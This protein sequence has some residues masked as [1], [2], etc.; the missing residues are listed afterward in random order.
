MPTTQTSEDTN[1]RRP[2]LRARDASTASM[3]NAIRRGT[4][5]ISL[6]IPAGAGDHTHLPA[7]PVG[8]MTTASS[9]SIRAPARPPRDDDGGHPTAAGLALGAHAVGIAPA[10]SREHLRQGH[11]P[12]QPHGSK[13]N[14]LGAG[15]SRTTS[16]SQPKRRGDSVRSM[17]RRFLRRS[18]VKE[19]RGSGRLRKSGSDA[20]RLGHHLSYPDK[21]PSMGDGDGMQKRPQRSTSLP[22]K[23]LVTIGPTTPPRAEVGYSGVPQDEQAYDQGLDFQGEPSKPWLGMSPASQY[24]DDP[25]RPWQGMS[26]NVA[27]WTGQNDA[28]L[29]TT[30]TGLAPRPASSYARRAGSYSPPL[31]P[32]EIGVA[33]PHG[34]NNPRRKSRSASNLKKSSQFEGAQAERRMSEEIRYWRESVLAQPLSSLSND[35]ANEEV[36]QSRPISYENGEVEHEP[37]ST[38]ADRLSDELE[39]P[40]DPE[41]VELRRRVVELEAK[42]WHLQTAMAKIH[43]YLTEK[44]EGD[45]AVPDVLKHTLSRGSGETFSLSPKKSL[46]PSHRAPAGPR[47]RLQEICQEVDAVTGLSPRA[48]LD[49]ITDSIPSDSHVSDTDT[50]AGLGV[51]HHATAQ[52]EPE[53][54][55]ERHLSLSTVTTS[56]TSTTPRGG[57]S[58]R[59]LTAFLGGRH[60]IYKDGPSIPSRLDMEQT[61]EGSELS[62]SAGLEPENQPWPNPEV[63][64]SLDAHTKGGV[65][66]ES[67][68]NPEITHEQQGLYDDGDMDDDHDDDE[69]YTTTSETFITPTEDKTFGHSSSS[70]SS[71]FGDQGESE[72]KT[73][74]DTLLP[75]STMMAWSNKSTPTTTATATPSAMTAPVPL[76]TYPSGLSPPDPYPHPRYHEHE[77]EYEPH[78]QTETNASHLR[79][80]SLSQLT[81]NPSMNLVSTSTSSSS[82]AAAAAAAAA[83]A[84]APATTSF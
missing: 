69:E 68:N 4:V 22:I 80:M 79:H 5:K 70:S 82:S 72:E 40:K 1:V 54:S 13:S 42:V 56:A 50:P 63:S 73:T 15:E 39:T 77:H 31:R 43:R 74:T 23:E 30:W 47:A 55:A 2:S 38:P 7:Q 49:R 33:L 62:R 35:K 61:E 9:Q 37:Q 57:A 84:P 8:P 3:V 17:I 32:E 71:S 60:A 27:R 76:P 81:T 45:P 16:S 24:D 66:E 26:P 83:G 48:S 20:G 34:A 44:H 75:T 28:G 59:P 36:G 12:A 64:R 41:V 58:N 11:V 6:P 67:D 25:E 18:T 14:P 29:G 52:D 53:S 51:V 10:S 78:Q 21:S 65:K 46:F 19:G